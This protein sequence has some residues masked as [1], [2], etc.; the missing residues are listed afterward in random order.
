MSIV[1]F[2]CSQCGKIVEYL[3]MYHK[4]LKPLR[5]S[6]G[7]NLQPANE[8]SNDTNKGGV[9]DENRHVGKKRLGQ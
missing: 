5:C 2:R 9:S 7:G 3:R 1:R 8:N 4:G 6:C